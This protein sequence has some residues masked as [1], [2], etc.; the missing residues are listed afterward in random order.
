MAADSS[1]F[2]EQLVALAAGIQELREAMRENT[3]H[4]QQEI[5][6]RLTAHAS[7]LDAQYARL[8]S[9]YSN[10]H[11]GQH[12]P[13]CHTGSGEGYERSG[14]SYTPKLK[15]ESPKCDG[16]EPLCWLYKVKEYF[17]F[18][19]TPPGE[20]LRCVA[21]MLEG[22]AADWFRWHMKNKLIDGW[23]D[24]VHKFKLRFDPD[25]FVD[26]FGQLAKLRQRG[27]VME[28]QEEFEKILQH[29]TGASED[30][31][32]SLFH[33]GLKHHLQQEISLL[34][35]DSL[36]DSFTLA[37]ELEAKHTALLHSVH[38]RQAFGSNSGLARGGPPG[39]KPTQQPPLLP[40]PPKPAPPGLPGHNKHLSLAEK[41]AKDAKGLCYNCDQKWSRT[42]KCG[43][44]LILCGADEDDD[45]VTPYLDGL[46][47]YTPDLGDKI[48]VTADISSLNNFAGLQPPRSL[49]L[50]GRVGNQDVRVLI[51]GGS[52]HNFIHPALVARLQLPLRVVEPFRV[53][54]GNGD[55]LPYTS[56]CMGVPL[57][58]QSH[59]FIV[60]LFVLQIHGQDIVLGVQ[61]L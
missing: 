38:Q 48:A 18:Y 25:H 41:E 6:A 20:R 44:F 16:S 32:V 7:R 54:V 29:V 43:R 12:F 8:E 39:F 57:V 36:F 21:L 37:R 1:A 4:L 19:D 45:N 35:P 30:I 40:M 56:Q 14:S 27:S 24:F 49:R 53:Y 33:A 22:P 42:H 31:L 9:L 13:R 34:K 23:D 50:D 55:A 26:Y 5:V 17:E 58:M 59:M 51:D 61:W 10:R 2:A 3:S 60:D 46:G 15:L 52:T 47:C 28:Y 11:D